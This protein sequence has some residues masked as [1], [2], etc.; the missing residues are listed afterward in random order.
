MGTN[1][2]VAKKKQISLGRRELGLKQMTQRLFSLIKG[3]M[4]SLVSQIGQIP[5]GLALVH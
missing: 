3:R 2:R 5:L 1:G 4:A